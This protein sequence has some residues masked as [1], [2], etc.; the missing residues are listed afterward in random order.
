MKTVGLDGKEYI[1][2]PSKD[3]KDYEDNKSKL[4]LEARD[5]IH[6]C[7]PLATV[8]EEVM[9]LGCKGYGGNLIAD[10]LI[11]ELKILIE[12]HGEQHY[13]FIAHF[14]QS[15][16]GFAVYKNNDRLKEE[17]ANLNSIIYIELP[18]NKVKAWEEII[19]AKSC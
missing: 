17:W 6:R 11:P 14:H 7:F 5:V 19:Y 13:K 2:H 9:L 15:E 4:H 16:Q 8:Y 10:F 18:Y 12:V 1:I 3:N